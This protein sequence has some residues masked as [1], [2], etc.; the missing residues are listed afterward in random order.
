MCREC[1][2]EGGRLEKIRLSRLKNHFIFTV[3]STGSLK[4]VEIVQRA[5][6]GFEDKCRT[7]AETVQNVYMS[8]GDMVDDTMGE[9]LVT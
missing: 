4:A 6:Q 1:V 7:L 2:R 9:G 5:L 3:E 8:G